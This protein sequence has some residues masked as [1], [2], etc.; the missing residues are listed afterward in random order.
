MDAW[1]L[2]YSKPRQ[3]RL[4]LENLIRQGFKAYLPLIRNRRRRGGR[5]VSF[6]EPC[7]PRYLFIYLNDMT[8]NWGPIRSTVGV[9]KLIRFG[10][11]PA[12][13]PDG[14]V[15]SLLAREDEL[16]V[17]NLPQPEFDAGDLVRIV[18]G[19]MAGYEGIFKA[20]TGRERVIILLDIVG[21]STRVELPDSQIES[22]R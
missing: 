3:E 2:L 14:L 20:K 16:G 15:D 21:N 10:D 6:V 7:F 1:Y 12:R 22:V 17:Q 11:L 19:A 13:V 9:S 8:D 5:Y 18:E 4:A